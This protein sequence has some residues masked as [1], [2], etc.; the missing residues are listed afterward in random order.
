MNPNCISVKV[1][2]PLKQVKQYY[3]LC[4]PFRFVGDVAGLI[5][6]E[7]S[8]RTRVVSQT[9]TVDKHTYGFK[10]TGQLQVSLQP[11]FFLFQRMAQLKRLIPI[12]VTTDCRLYVV[13]KADLKKETTL[14][15]PCS[16][17]P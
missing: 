7:K 5:N 14:V 2:T 16:V 3:Q 8:S 10:T 17:S 12:R 15:S 13:L 9:T 4:H 6:G 11:Q 1:V